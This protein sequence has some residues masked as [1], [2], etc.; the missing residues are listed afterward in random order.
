MTKRPD[1]APSTTDVGEKTQDLSYRSS[2]LDASDPDHPAVVEARIQART[3]YLIIFGLVLTAAIAAGAALWHAGHGSFLPAVYAI[4][5]Y[6]VS[7]GAVLVGCLEYITRHSR[8]QQALALQIALQ[9]QAD[10]L[11]LVGLL[12]E[13]LQQR[14]YSGYVARAEDDLSALRTGTGPATAVGRAPAA[15]RSGAEVVKMRRRADRNDTHFS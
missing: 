5:L 7:C 1:D 2:R 15:N 6:A 8:A 9:V 3:K 11:R 4:P 10:Q 14:W 13:E 12:D